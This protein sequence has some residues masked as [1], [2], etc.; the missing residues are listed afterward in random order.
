MA[1]LMMNPLRGTPEAWTEALATALPGED[2]RFFPNV[3]NPADIEVFIVGFPTKLAELPKLPNLKLNISLLAG[4]DGLIAN[5]HMPKAPLVKVEPPSG[6]VTMNEYCLLL[7]LYHHRSL[8]QYRRFQA[9]HE[10]TPLPRK[11]AEE[12]TVGFL[13][14]GTLGKPMAEHIKRQ[15]FHVIGWARTPKPGSSI[16]TFAGEAGFAPFL[17]KSEILVN[18]LPLTEETRGILNAKAFAQMPK[19]AAVI[20]LARGGHL[21]DKDLIAAL[22]SGQL[23]SATLDVTEPEPLPADSPLWDHPGVTILPH[24]ARRPSLAETMPQIVENMRRLR[25]GQPLILRVDTSA[26]Y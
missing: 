5:P 6:D 2:V 17:A 4:V 21:V 25:S 1:I 26:G 19:G 20:N 18:M 16:E 23:G 3:G 11:R 10:W 7:V 8:P 14:Q 9:K 15:G 24:V 12:R 22:D 13:G